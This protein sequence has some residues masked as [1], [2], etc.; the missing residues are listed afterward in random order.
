MTQTQ[1]FA[2]LSQGSTTKSQADYAP[3]HAPDAL[4]STSAMHADS[5]LI[6]YV[7]ALTLALHRP[8]WRTFRY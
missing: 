5:D 6:I 1:H 2:R 3:G 8:T 4:S 7:Q